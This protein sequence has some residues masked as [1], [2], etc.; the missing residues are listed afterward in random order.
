MLQ[1]GCSRL[2]MKFC[3]EGYGRLQN[4]DQTF[5]LNTEGSCGML[6]MRFK[7]SSLSRPSGFEESFALHIE[8]KKRRLTPVMLVAK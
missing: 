5:S 2:K 1:K 3:R 7:S 4:I 8:R 6:G